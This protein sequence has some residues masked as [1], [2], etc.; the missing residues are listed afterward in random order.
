MAKKRNKNKF[1]LSPV[2]ATY[3]MDIEGVEHEFAFTDISSKKLTESES[4]LEAQHEMVKE[5]TKCITEGLSED[6]AE[7]TLDLL[8]D[9]VWENMGAGAWIETL[10][11]GRVNE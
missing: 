3:F 11:S 9:G 4:T 1:T 2:V 10:A 5:N 7:K 6:E 8:F